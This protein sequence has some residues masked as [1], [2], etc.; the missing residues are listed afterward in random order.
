MFGYFF[1]RK[2]DKQISAISSK[3]NTLESLHKVCQLAGLGLQEPV[4]NESRYLAR[5]LSDFLS[6]VRSD[7]DA[8]QK[9]LATAELAAS[10]ALNDCVDTLITYV[11]TTLSKQKQDYPGFRI[12]TSAYGNEYLE[13]LSA[14][15]EV[16]K[17]VVHSRMNRTDRVELYAGLLDS[18]KR[19]HLQVISNFALK[20]PQIEAVAEIV[21]QSGQV[22]PSTLIAEKILAAC[23]GQ[24]NTAKLSLALQAKYERRNGQDICIGAEA[25]ARLTVN[26]QPVSPSLFVPIA[27]Q[28][29]LVEML[30]RWVLMEV[31]QLLSDDPTIPRVSVNVAAVELASPNYAKDVLDC[32]QLMGVDPSR[33]ELEITERVVVEDGMSTEHLIRLGEYGVKISIDDFGTGQTR[34]DY[35]ARMPVH[36]VKIDMS[37]VKNFVAAPSSYSTL[38]KAIHAVGSACSMEIVAEG[39]E[40]EEVRDSLIQLGITKFQGYVYGKP[41]PVQAFLANHRADF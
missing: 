23:G 35:F 8:A 12:A 10:C 32:I 37:L 29:K 19:S 25:L 33:L 41:L 20:L 5:A 2:F 16:D 14:I 1:S 9:Y 34:F 4:L 11:K 13:T 31:L 27:E 18:Q 17:V 30:D 28:A 36:V 24:D 40:T 26:G 21:T 39:V 38:L 3:L 15:Q 6:N 22:A 7:K